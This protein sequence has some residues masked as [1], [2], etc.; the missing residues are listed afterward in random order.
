MTMRS[1]QGMPLTINKA[2]IACLDLSLTKFRL[3][4]GTQVLINDPEN[5]EK[6]RQE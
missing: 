1:S 5:L 6:I 2:K 4:M 3:P